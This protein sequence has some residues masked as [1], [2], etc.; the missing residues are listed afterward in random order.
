MTPVGHIRNERKEVAIATDYL[1]TLENSE[2]EETMVCWRG[3]GEERLPRRAGG[4]AASPVL[5][6]SSAYWQEEEDEDRKSVV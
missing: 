3:G 2:S 6:F 4:G 5:T 1:G